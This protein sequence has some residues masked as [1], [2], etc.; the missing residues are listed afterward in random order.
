MSLEVP[1]GLMLS[2]WTHNF[3]ELRGWEKIM[4]STREAWGL[5]G[6]RK[7]VMV[8]HRSN[9]SISSSS[10]I[11]IPMSPIISFLPSDKTQPGFECLARPAFSMLLEAEVGIEVKSET[12]NKRFWRHCCAADIDRPLVPATEFCEMQQ[13]CL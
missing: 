8:N 6:R 5:G 9:E 13:L 1:F 2:R 10:Y 12:A 7:R 4:G 11:N 3:G